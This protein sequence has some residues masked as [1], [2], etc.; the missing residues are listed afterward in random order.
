MTLDELNGYDEAAFVEWLDGVYE[1]SP[2]VATRAASMRPFSTLVALKQGLQ[3]VVSDAPLPERLALIRAH[4]ELAGAQAAAGALTA[5][6]QEEQSTAGL[7]DAAGERAALLA[8][9][10][11]LNKQYRDRFEFP[12][13]LAVKGPDG[14]GLSIE[15]IVAAMRRRL[16][17]HPDDEIQESLRQIHRI[18]ELRLNQRLALTPTLGLNVVTWCDALA[19]HSEATDALTCTYLSDSHQACARDLLRWMQE[20]GMEAHIDALGNVIGRYAAADDAGGVQVGDRAAIDDTVAHG[21]AVTAGGRATRT[22]LTGS[23]YDTVR[24]G[25]KYDG[26]V[27]ILIPIAV[28]GE[29]HRRG[30][31]LPFHIEVIGFAEEE[32]VRYRSA[33]LGSSGLTA[34]FDS[35][36]LDRED[37]HGVALRDALTGA[38]HSIDDI[39]R[40]ARSR[41]DLIAF[42][43]LHIEQGPVLLSAGLPLG[44]VSAIAGSRRYLVALKGVAGHA[45]STPMTMRRDAAAAAA[46]ITLLV[47]RRCSGIPGLVGTVGRLQVPNGSIN[48]IPGACQMSLDIRAGDDA[49]RD[50]AHDDILDG[51]AEICRRRGI[52]FSLE[53][54]LASQTVHCAPWLRERL[55]GSVAA[56]GMAVQTLPSGAGHDAVEMSKLTDVGML[57][58]RCGNGGISHNPL[59]TVS[60]DDLSLAADVFEAMLAGLAADERRFFP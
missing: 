6:S 20:A 5:A 11:A 3:Q 59:E 39:P 17:T 54:A 8:Q 58:I 18:A 7:T 52:D 60:A 28:I 51:I 33:F 42:L 49:V 4:P 56:Q 40:A 19:Q 57:F 43:E 22:L 38:G 32:G 14:R 23:H 48:V 24:N 2:W 37:E 41:D 50:A 16:A 30:E 53:P 15:Q 21:A 25:G 13:V 36:L 9:L 12:F 45:G 44:V 10:Q 31:R 47:E 1:H 34:S 26:R 27:G 35:T 29:M 55:A 46:E